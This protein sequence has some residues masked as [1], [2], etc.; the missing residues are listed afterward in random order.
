M[1]TFINEHHLI[2]INTLKKEVITQ[3]NYAKMLFSLIQLEVFSH[4]TVYTVELV[5]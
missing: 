5:Q 4:K 2:R 3:E 1:N